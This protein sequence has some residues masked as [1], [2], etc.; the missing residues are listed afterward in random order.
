MKFSV[1]VLMLRLQALLERRKFSHILGSV[2]FIKDRFPFRRSRTN[3][4]A[5]YSIYMDKNGILVEIRIA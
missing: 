4:P 5:L 3:R 1:I 2:L